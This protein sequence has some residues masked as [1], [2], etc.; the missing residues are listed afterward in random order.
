MQVHIPKLNACKYTCTCKR[1]YACTN[2]TTCMFVSSER[3]VDTVWCSYAQGMPRLHVSSQRARLFASFFFV[4]ATLNNSPPAFRHC[5]AGR[6]IKFAIKFFCLNLG[7]FK[8][9]AFSL[10]SRRGECRE[11][12]TFLSKAVKISNLA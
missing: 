6:R 2:A 7:T 9:S 4:T 10:P 5:N 11:F 1:Q 12:G 8:F 3:C